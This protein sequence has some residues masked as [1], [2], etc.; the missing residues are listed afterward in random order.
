MSDVY[1][2]LY[3]DKS[4]VIVEE[5]GKNHIDCKRCGKRELTKLGLNRMK[6]RKL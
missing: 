1:R 5:N 3:C 2:C 6:A 4:C